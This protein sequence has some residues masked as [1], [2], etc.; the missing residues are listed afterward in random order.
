VSRSRERGSSARS[1]VE[2]PRKATPTAVSPDREEMNLSLH[3]GPR[4]FSAD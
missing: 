4:E 1:V 3:T 2:S